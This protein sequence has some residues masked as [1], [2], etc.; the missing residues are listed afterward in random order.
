MQQTK[1]LTVAASG[2]VSTAAEVEDVLEYGLDVPTL[3]SSTVTVQGS[4]DGGAT[5]RNLF[6]E[7]NNQVLTFA[8]STG[9][10]HIS[11]RALRHVIGCS[12][13]QILCGSAQ[14]SARTFTLYLRRGVPS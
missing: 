11:A 2:T 4:V 8:A 3:T 1:T 10:F 7:F 13:I 9:A 14:G 6:D 5:F 12:H